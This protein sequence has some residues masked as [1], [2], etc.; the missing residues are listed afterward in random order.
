MR[1]YITVVRAEWANLWQFALNFALQSVQLPIAVLILFYIYQSVSGGKGL[2]GYSAL[3]LSLYFVG[4]A[5]S[6]QVMVPA[7]GTMG[8]SW[9]QINNGDLANYLCRPVDYLWFRYAR[10]A[11]QAGMV[12]LCATL[13]QMVVRLIL[14]TWSPVATLQYMLA[15]LL[16][17]S[18]WFMWWFLVGAL[19]FWWE[20]PFGLRDIL[21]NVIA[22]LSGQLLPIDLLHPVLQPFIRWLPFQGLA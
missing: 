7:L 18:L 15:L 20:R 6:T 9:E 19:S 4:V 14:G 8:E 10:K 3:K 2:G 13:I 1:K 11:A 16:A 21:W 17:Y 12:A 5:V 22:I